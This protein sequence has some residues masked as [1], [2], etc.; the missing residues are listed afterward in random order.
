MRKNIEADEVRVL[1]WFRKNAHGYRKARKRAD[2]LPFMFPKLADRYFRALVSSLKHKGHLASTCNRGYW[3][4][5][6]CTNDH[7]EISATL[8]S[9]QEM[10]AKALDM[11]KGYGELERKFKTQGQGQMTIGV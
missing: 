7:N 6:L 3:A 1:D 5:P 4:I 11:L 9:I 10:K 8:E 2:I